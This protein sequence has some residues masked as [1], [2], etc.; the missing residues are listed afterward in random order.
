[1]PRYSLADQNAAAVQVLRGK[2]TA[3]ELS[4]LLGVSVRTI[5]SWV[6]S[7][8]RATVTRAVTQETDRDVTPKSGKKPAPAPAPEPKPPPAAAATEKK[9]PADDKKKGEWW[10]P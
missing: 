3:L 1:M 4:E 8:N 9:Q 5:D 10:E 2:K 7:Y 6:R